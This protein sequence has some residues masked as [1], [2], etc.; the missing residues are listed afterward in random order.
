[1]AYDGSVELISGIKQANNGTFAL[2]D[3]SAVRITDTTRL[4]HYDLS[5]IGVYRFVFSITGNSTS[6]E[7]TI[8]FGPTSWSGAPTFT[9]NAR[10]I[11]C[12]APQS[13]YYKNLTYEIEANSISGEV[14]VLPG[15][16]S[17]T[18]E[19]LVAEIIQ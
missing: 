12:I 2:V 1:M 14:T 17:G 4:S 6:Q 9:N 13:K 10:V 15:A 11:E 8:G 18:I 3:A 7:F 16:S 5:K 19:F